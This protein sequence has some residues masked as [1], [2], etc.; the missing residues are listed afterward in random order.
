MATAAE[1]HVRVLAP[2]VNSYSGHERGSYKVAEGWGGGGLRTWPA[3]EADP[4]AR[5][6][7]PLSQTAYIS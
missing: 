5:P 3:P 7:A 1:H 6:P 4:A 2:P